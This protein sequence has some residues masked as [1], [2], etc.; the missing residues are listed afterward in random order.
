MFLQVPKPGGA[1][2]EGWLVT[3]TYHGDDDHSEFRVYDAQNISATPIASCR[4]PQ[5][6]P[7]GFHG[8]W[9]PAEEIASSVARSTFDFSS[10]HK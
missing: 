8:T 6:V 4:M 9:I 2:D 10:F 1:E 3:F 7:G 5:R